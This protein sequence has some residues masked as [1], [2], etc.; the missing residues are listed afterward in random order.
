M[1]DEIG[2]LEAYIKGHELLASKYG[3]KDKEAD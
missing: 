3:L 2:N 1:E